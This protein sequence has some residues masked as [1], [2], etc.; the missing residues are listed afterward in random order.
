MITMK[1]KR[2]LRV[3][4]LLKRDLSDI[5]TTRVRDP[6]VKSVFITY[7]K[8]SDDLKYAKIYYRSIKTDSANNKLKMALERVTNFLKLELGRRTE[9]RYIPELRFFYDSGI[10]EANRIDHLIEQ[11]KQDYSS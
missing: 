1:V 4:E 11:I 9:L 3:A 7:V 2:S 6:L 5:I 10:D 8:V